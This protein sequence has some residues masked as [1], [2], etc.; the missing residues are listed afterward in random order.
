[1]SQLT[2]LQKRNLCEWAKNVIL[3][4][5]MLRGELN[6]EQK[7][8]IEKVTIACA[9]ADGSNYDELRKQAQKIGAF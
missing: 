4:A 1:M 7:D 8:F 2:S 3:D 9:D 5:R 6:Q